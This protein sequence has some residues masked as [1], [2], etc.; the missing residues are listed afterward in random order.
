MAGGDGKNETL[1]E[2]ARQRRRLIELNQLDAHAP[3]VALAHTG[4]ES[5]TSLFWLV[6]LI[7]LLFLVW[8]VVR[9]VIRPMW[10]TAEKPRVSDFEDLEAG[11][12]RD[13]HLLV[14]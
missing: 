8:F 10:C 1:L 7:P 14:D 6:A 11:M 3:V 4:A 12:S 13:L 2:L 9:R 5:D